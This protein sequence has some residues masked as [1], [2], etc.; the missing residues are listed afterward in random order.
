MMRTHE[1]KCWPQYFDQIE[2]EVKKFEL[3]KNDRGF[4]L[5]DRLILKEYLPKEERY[6]GRSLQLKVTYKIESSEWPDGLQPGYCVLGFEVINGTVIH[7][8]TMKQELL[9][10]DEVRKQLAMGYSP[11]LHGVVAGDWIIHDAGVAIA[12]PIPKADQTEWR[13]T[14]EEHRLLPDELVKEWCGKAIAYEPE[15][16][17]WEVDDSGY[18][19]PSLTFCPPPALPSIELDALI[20]DM[21]TTLTI[22]F[23]FDGD[24]VEVCLF[25]QFNPFDSQE[26]SDSAYEAIAETLQAQCDRVSSLNGTGE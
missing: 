1:L 17:G 25:F 10:L 7:C 3:R 9:P 18:D 4:A 6:T 8:P 20:E 15:Y 2:K 26:V 14:A 11:Y 12:T 24:R 22:Q 19:S 21:T 5:G 16:E 23:E 13:L